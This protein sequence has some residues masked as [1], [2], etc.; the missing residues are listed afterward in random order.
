MC[1]DSSRKILYRTMFEAVA[2]AGFVLD[3]GDFLIRIIG[4][5][6]WHDVCASFAHIVTNFLS[7]NQSLDWERTQI[8]LARIMT[9]PNVS[10]ATIFRQCLN[11]QAEG[12]SI[13]SGRR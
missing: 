4:W 9:A 1:G 7:D 11:A 10:P 5:Q 6:I 3:L 8:E 13:S 2:L 12:R